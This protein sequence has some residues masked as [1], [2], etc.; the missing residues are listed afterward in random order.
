MPNW[1]EHDLHIVGKKAD[2]DRFLKTGFNGDELQLAL[3]PA[4][5]G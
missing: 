3:V 1:T 2:I 4:R 5:T